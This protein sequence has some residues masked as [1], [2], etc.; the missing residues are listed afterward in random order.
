[1]L[2][3]GTA[4][5][6]GKTLTGVAMAA[7]TAGPAKGMAAS[8]GIG[9]GTGLAATLGAAA[10]ALGAVALMTWSV[11]VASRY[12]S[13][14][15]ESRR[16][17]PGRAERR[18]F[19]NSSRH[20]AATGTNSIPVESPWESVGQPARM[21]TRGIRIRVETPLEWAWRSANSVAARVRP[22]RLPFG[23]SL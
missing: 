10:G 12:I 2:Q 15:M 20:A 19:G 22:I 14:N 9:A 11:S 16:I 5:A 18:V 21:K 3:S 4:A 7:K 8:C 13:N 17:V 23:F 6:K 1:M